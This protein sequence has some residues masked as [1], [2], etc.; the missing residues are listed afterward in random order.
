M[1]VPMASLNKFRFFKKSKW[2]LKN[3]MADPN[4]LWE[5]I[6]QGAKNGRHWEPA[7]TTKAQQEQKTQLEQKNALL[8]QLLVLRTYYLISWFD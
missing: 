5:K 6:S 3:K 8:R 2:P 1:E 4:K 7:I